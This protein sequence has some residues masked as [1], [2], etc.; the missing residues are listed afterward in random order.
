MSAEATRLALALDR[1]VYD[2][3]YLALAQRIRGRVVTA[4]GRFARA[5]APTEHG[6]TVVMLTDLVTAAETDADAP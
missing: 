6:G 3:V 2:C 1:P 4:D 5:L